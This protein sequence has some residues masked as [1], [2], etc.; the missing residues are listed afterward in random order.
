M[1]VLSK[2]KARVI[3]AYDKIEPSVNKELHGMLAELVSFVESK[4]PEAVETAEAFVVKEVP[5]LA[6]AAVAEGPKVISEAVVIGEKIAG[7]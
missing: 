5:T 4:I 6:A 2:L 1:G 7:V 3:A